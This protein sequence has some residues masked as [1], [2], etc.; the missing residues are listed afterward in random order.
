MKDTTTIAAIATPLGNGAISIVRM[1]GD[2]ALSIAAKLFKTS[3]LKDFNDAAPKQ[4]Y[5]GTFK[6]G[7]ISDKCVAV[8]FKAPNSYTGEDMVEF[9]CHGGVRRRRRR[10]Y[11]QRGIDSGTRS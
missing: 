9:Q 3:S 6:N 8:Y 7:K 11:D 2:N 10:R 4:A 5:Y 1:S